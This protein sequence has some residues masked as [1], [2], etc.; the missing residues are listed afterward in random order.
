MN[1]AQLVDA[2]ASKSGLSKVDAKKGLDAMIRIAAD[3]LREGDKITLSGLGT[4][5]VAKTKGR[6]GRNPRTGAPIKIAPKN[7]VKFRAGNELSGHVQ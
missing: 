7:V 4:F 3:T 1:K 6:T 2:I 5:S